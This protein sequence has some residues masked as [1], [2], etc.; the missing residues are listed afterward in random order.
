MHTTVSVMLEWTM[1]VGSYAKDK[2]DLY[3]RPPVSSRSIFSIILIIMKAAAAA[4][5]AG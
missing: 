4:A 1:Q 5:A 3:A 2:L